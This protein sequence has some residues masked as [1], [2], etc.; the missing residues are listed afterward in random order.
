MVR[1]KMGLAAVCTVPG[2]ASCFQH[3]HP[4]IRYKPAPFQDCR[5]PEF[6]PVRLNTVMN[7]PDSSLSYP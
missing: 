2:G 7:G 6:N 3:L 4:M 1:E 5:L